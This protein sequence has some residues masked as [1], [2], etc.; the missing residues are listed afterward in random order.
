[1][2][3]LFASP[4]A[5]T[6][7]AIIPLLGLLVWHARRR[8]RRLLAS[9]GDPNALSVAHRS[10]RGWRGASWAVALGLLVIAAAGP[11]WGQGPSPPTMPGC[12]IM[13]VVDLSRSMLARD[14]LPNRLA[15]AK[16]SLEELV[17]H[18]QAHGGHRL[19]IVAFAGRAQIVCPLTNDYDHVRTKLA[20]H[21]ADPLPPA[22]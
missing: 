4:E 3:R 13:L 16:E 5:L 9:L 8:R 22:L 1:M 6:A 14:A 20:S 17:D 10:R 7:L 21:T 15:R 12:D 11:R 19:G 2:S 18:V